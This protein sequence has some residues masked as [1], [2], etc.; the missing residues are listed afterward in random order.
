MVFQWCRI[1]VAFLCCMTFFC[2]TA[3]AQF[4]SSTLTGVVTDPTKALVPQAEIKA[5]N[6]ATNTES[7]A[8]ADTEGR[9]TFSNLRPGAYTIKA[10][11]KG[12][13]QFVSTGLQLQVNQAARLDITLSVG[14]VNEEVS[15][16]AEM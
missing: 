7:S 2:L 6:E 16:V 9:F 8:V 10:T 3:L 12:F 11:G 14:Q 13:K 1:R 5:I 15:I 4:D